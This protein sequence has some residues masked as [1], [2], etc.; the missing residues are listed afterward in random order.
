MGASLVRSS[1]CQ[2]AVA[3]MCDA[4]VCGLIN[5]TPQESF[6]WGVKQAPREAP[7]SECCGLSFGPSRKANIFRR[8]P[9]VDSLR[10]ESGSSWRASFAS[11]YVRRM[12]T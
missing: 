12:S 11:C 6:K 3:M 4:D 5:K 9:K 10:I 2:L 8:D 7:D 1:S